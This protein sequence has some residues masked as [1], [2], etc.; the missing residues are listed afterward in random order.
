MTGWDRA[1]VPTPRLPPAPGGRAV[2]RPRRRR[3][4]HGSRGGARCRQPRPEDRTRREA[5]LRLG[6][7]V[8]VV[9]DGPRGPAVPAATGVPTGLR[10]P[11]GAT[12]PVGQ[13]TPPRVPPAVPDPP[14]RS[15]RRGLQ[16]RGPLLLG[17]TVA[18]RSDRRRPH[19][20]PPPSGH[21]GPGPGAP[22]DPERRAARCRLPLLRR[23]SRRCPA[24]PVPGAHRR[25]R[26]RRRRGQLHPGGR[27]DTHR[28]P[29]GGGHRAA[30]TL[31]CGVRI[32]DQRPCGGQRHRRLGRRREGSRRRLP[33][34][35]HP[36]G[37]GGARHGP[38][39]PAPLRR[40]RR[41]PR[42]PG[43][44]DDLRGAVARYGPR[45]SG[46]DRYGLSGTSTTCSTRPTTPPPPA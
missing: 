17:G 10:E 7:L 20:G 41:H 33:P 19:R 24:D 29:G 28:R 27:P 14:L 34:A 37:Q 1:P 6:D 5:R 25:A 12:A 36:T 46:H 44:A 35:L 15:R 9:E 26:S 31:R 42:P 38:G 11:G 22:A 30:R 45:L 2:R 8:Q 43:Q 23:P 21:P 4:R 39:G 3:R 40:R 18:L 32:P 16:G 13:R